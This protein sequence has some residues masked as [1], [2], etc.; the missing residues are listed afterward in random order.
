MT[1]IR[2]RTCP[3]PA[4]RAPARTRCRAT[5]R[6]AARPRHARGRGPVRRSA[7][8]AWG[9]CWGRSSA[10]GAADTTSSGLAWPV[11]LGERAASVRGEGEDTDVWRRGWFWPPRPVWHFA[12]ARSAAS[13]VECFALRLE[14]WAWRRAWLR[15]RG[16]KHPTHDAANRARIGQFVRNRP[17]DPLRGS[18][19]GERALVVGWGRERTV[20]V[21]RGLQYDSVC[22]RGLQYDPPRSRCDDKGLQRLHAPRNAHRDRPKAGQTACL[23][24][25]SR[26][27]PASATCSQTTVSVRGACNTPVSVRGACNTPVSVRG[28]CNTPASVRGGELERS[29]ADRRA[30]RGHE[31]AP[32]ETCGECPLTGVS[33]RSDHHCCL[34][35]PLRQPPAGVLA[36]GFTPGPKAPNFRVRAMND[37]DRFEF[38][39]GFRTIAVILWR[40]SGVGAPARSGGLAAA[41]PRRPFAAARARGLVPSHRVV[42]R[43]R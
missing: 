29:P 14:G 37:L 27:S 41:T 30:R 17:R 23:Q 32:A 25:G 8:R 3:S 35:R 11:G 15:R 39:D 43:P 6:A 26:R 33:P 19:F 2:R 13:W 24:T 7:G 4:A 9:L 5:P 1:A 21:R 10:C 40:S 20:F 28:A 36:D 16:A 18:W 12:R 38:T 31:P 22:S 34:R 42:P